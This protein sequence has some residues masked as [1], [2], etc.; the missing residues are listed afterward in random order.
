MFRM[1]PYCDAL[2]PVLVSLSQVL[3]KIDL[4]GADPDRV[5][6]EIE[7]VRIFLVSANI[8]FLHKLL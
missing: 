3:N 2:T 4:P 6:A 5:A 7:E 1:I 8:L